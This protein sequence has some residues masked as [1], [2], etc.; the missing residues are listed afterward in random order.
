MSGFRA[1]STQRFGARMNVE[2][3]SDNVVLDVACLSHGGFL[4]KV[5]K[6]ILCLVILLFGVLSV[7]A[8]EDGQLPPPPQYRLELVYIFEANPTEYIFLVGNVGFRSVDSLKKFIGDLPPG[9]ILEW[10]PGC[11]R[12]GGEPL[13]SSSEDME[14]FKAFCAEKNI[15]FVLMPAG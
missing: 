11:L 12:S 1:R 8:Q 6:H 14:D 10:A 13:L 7:Q 3:R 4:M 15:K 2:R 9:S 5:S